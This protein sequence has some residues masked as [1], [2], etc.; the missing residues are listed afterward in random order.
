MVRLTR[1]YTKTGDA[2]ETSLGNTE[3]VRKSGARIAVVG[4]VDETNSAVGVARIETG[5][6]AQPEPDAMLARI[7]ND[8]FDLGADFSVPVTKE[9]EPSRTTLRITAHQV[10]RLEQEI[11]HLNEHLK[12]LESFILPGGAPAAAHL[13]VAR[14]AA[15]RA[16]RLAWALAEQENV[17][18]ESVR[19]LNRLSDHL[20]VLC[21]WVNEQTG[22]G[23]V[24]WRPG[25]GG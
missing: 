10:E 17:S 15:R 19:Y 14:A 24:L 16:E 9:A 25:A 18:P 22:T 21:R 8:L 5:K 3:R 20:F 2:G 23:D 7:Q 12:P 1:I 6:L 13:H 11:D 4:A